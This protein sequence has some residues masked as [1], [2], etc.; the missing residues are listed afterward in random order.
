MPMGRKTLLVKAI[1]YSL[2]M[3]FHIKRRHNMVINRYQ[4]NRPETTNLTDD[5]KRTVGNVARVIRII[6][7]RAPWTPMCLNLALVAKLLLYNRG[8]ETSLHIGFK[9]R[10]TTK[11]EGHAWLTIGDKLITGWLKDLED[12]KELKGFRK[13]KGLNLNL[14][15]KG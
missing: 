2:F 11:Y 7:K 13:D 15:F 4:R 3:E 12:Y 8:I 10:I 1:G 5:Q 6:D 9:S 14:N